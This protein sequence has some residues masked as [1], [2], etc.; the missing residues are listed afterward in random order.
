[1]GMVLPALELLKD[2][3][4]NAMSLTTLCQPLAQ[5]L[6]NGIYRRFAA[7]FEDKDFI[8]AAVT[9]PVCKTSWIKDDTK[10]A[11]ADLLL[12]QELNTII[13]E[14]EQSRQVLETLP[15]TVNGMG[16]LKAGLA[17]HTIA[18]TE[19]VNQCKSLSEH[20]NRIDNFKALFIKTNTALPT[21]APCERLFSYGSDFLTHKR[22]RMSA[23]NF[24]NAA[25]HKSK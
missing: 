12:F 10:R 9:H 6:L 8:L 24:L 13:E 15:L 4:Y 21:S 20:L 5:A 17:S 18:A 2:K 16:T 11:D 3:I 23:K 25:S 22:H 1:M 14:Q 19:L 7:D